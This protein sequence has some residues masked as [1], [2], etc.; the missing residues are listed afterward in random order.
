MYR[1]LSIDGGGM[2]G[3]IPAVWLYH[4]EQRLG[5]PLFEHF[6]LFAGTSTGSILAAGLAAGI[7]TGRLVELYEQHGPQIFPNRPIDERR[8]GLREAIS[9][10]FG[11]KYE[12]GPLADVLRTYF[13]NLGSE[14]MLGELK[15]LSLIHI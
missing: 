11:P 9:R 2:R 10:L 4:L 6:D 1:V 14:I 5:S 12:E 3:I 13:S 7:E 8:S 15:K